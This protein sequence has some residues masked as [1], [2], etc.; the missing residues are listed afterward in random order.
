MYEQKITLDEFDEDDEENIPGIYS[1]K[2]PPKN[3][4]IHEQYLSSEDL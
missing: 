1:E 4:C 2:M 3:L